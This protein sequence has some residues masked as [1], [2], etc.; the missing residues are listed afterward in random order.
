MSK[1]VNNST[2]KHGVNNRYKYGNTNKSNTNTVKSKSDKLFYGIMTIVCVC[3]LGFGLLY[4][5]KDSN[6]DSDSKDMTD[7]S[8]LNTQQDNPAAD[9]GSNVTEPVT[10]ITKGSDIAK[11]SADVITDVLSDETVS[12]DNYDYDID[13]DKPPFSWYGTYINNEETGINAY[14]ITLW[15]P[16]QAEP[17]E[18]ISAYLGNRSSTFYKPIEEDYIDGVAIYKITNLKSGIYSISFSVD[19]EI[20]PEGVTSY[21]LSEDEYDTLMLRFNSQSTDF[22]D[23][24]NYKTLS[25]YISTYTS[26]AANTFSLIDMDISRD[27]YK[28]RLSSLARQGIYSYT[29]W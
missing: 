19:S 20:E 3:V 16:E 10:R 9:S 27:S 5:L 14:L 2:T 7:K 12:G 21:L 11:E 1:D 25:E 17:L 18:F 26:A 15:N 6:S 4:I 8:I 23:I 13:N 24:L 28:M 22:E 29:E